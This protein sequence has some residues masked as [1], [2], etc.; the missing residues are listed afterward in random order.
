MY[1]AERSSIV[2]FWLGFFSAER[3]ISYL[4]CSLNGNFDYLLNIILS[5]EVCTDIGLHQCIP[6]LHSLPP[7]LTV[8]SRVSRFEIVAINSYIIYLWAATK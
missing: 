4:C 7:T 8:Y 6:I 2:E 3:I 1:F 5:A